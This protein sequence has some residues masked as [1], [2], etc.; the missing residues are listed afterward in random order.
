MKLC[1]G[2]FANVLLL[3]SVDNIEKKKLLNA[4]VKSVDPSCSLSSSAVTALL[5]CTSNLPD[6]RSNALGN[7]I[8]GAEN[9]LPQ[10]VAEYFANK[11]ITKFLEYGK[12]K[13][14]VLAIRELVAK[15][16]SISGNDVVE[17]VS[18][19]TKNALLMQSTVVLSDFLA[20]VFLFVTQVDNRAGKEAAKEASM[21]FVV[22]FTELQDTISFVVPQ[23][24]GEIINTAS[25]LFIDYLASVK[26]RY[27]SVKTLLYNDNPKPFY[28]F[29]VPNYAIHSVERVKNKQFMNVT[30]ESLTAIS[31]FLIIEGI[32]GLGKTMMMQHLL[33]NSIENFGKLRR[34]PIFLPLKD[35]SESNKK[36]ENFV[37]SMVQDFN[38][39]IT[40][41]DFTA[42]L[43]NGLF[44]LL[45]DGLDEIDY[46]HSGCFEREI[47]R[48]TDRYP[49]NCFVISSR[50]FQSFISFA[51][52]SKV[53]L[54]P[55]TKN[56]ALE[57]IDKADFRPDKPEIRQ[58]FRAALDKSLFKTHRNFAQN[59]LL[60][61]IMLLTF[62]RF[63]ELPAKMHIF[64]REAFLALSVTHDANKGAF[65]RTLK[66]G[67]NIDDIEVYFSEICFR[68]YRDEKYEFS[69]GEFAGYFGKLYKS[70][71]TVTASDFLH[72]MCHN[73][74]LMYFES[75]KY[76]F[77]HRS[78]Q[79]YF[80]AVFMSKQT[81]EFIG[82]LGSF[83]EKRSTR[84]FA[85][86]AFPM[87]YDIIPERVEQFIFVPYMS[88]LFAKCDE[89]NGYWTFLEEEYPVIYYEN[90]DVD[91]SAGN[92]P[93]SY[94][95]ELILMQ[96]EYSHTLSS[97]E[98]P[99]YDSLVTEE[100]TEDTAPL[101]IQETGA[102][103]NAVGVSVMEWPYYEI[104]ED[105]Y[106]PEPEI[107]G[108]KLEFEVADVL[109]HSEDY[110]ELL[111]VL[112][113]DG[114]IFK[115]EYNAARAYLKTLTDKIQE[116]RDDLN[117]L[118]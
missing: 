24:E 38:P 19:T 83:F 20:G 47:E 75:G 51:R 104:D 82:K 55:F 8:S 74:C 9:A 31:N 78:F 10:K 12:R 43:N 114:F 109:L 15:D 34:I 115:C 66:T 80:A 76:H 23:K 110:A 36:I 2:T 21:D 30:A 57:L 70:D 54:Q 14:A 99:F 52:F 37:F 97:D 116:R 3:C 40:Y 89:G 79:E 77:I 117:D 16:E 95:L 113:N 92:D 108:Y 106:P 11:I 85:N 67:L 50:P 27:G 84:V 39:R 100:V 64:Y 29:Y 68:S 49:K 90:G 1:F 13:L 41:E 18:G 69:D 56:Q 6:S 101:L 88:G 59:P 28:D 98:L 91:D 42:A 58:K 86:S 118:L 46:S 62:E 60:L 81:D 96:I 48:F 73:L 111:T 87:L 107:I 44:L 61:T 71:K 105:E 94:I 63:A 33:L 4:I 112:D 65:K 26:E 25:E 93:Q 35:Y 17:T 5:Q 103:G 32:G 72:D 45:F 7:V 22:S 102:D 53:K